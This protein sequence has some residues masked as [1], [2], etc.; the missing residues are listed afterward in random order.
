MKA[1]RT[2]KVASGGSH[3]RSRRRVSPKRSASGSALAASGIDILARNAD[4]VP[5]LEARRF[6]ASA[7]FGYD[8]GR[9]RSCGAAGILAQ[10]AAD[11]KP[12]RVCNPRPELNP[13]L[14]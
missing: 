2:R 13:K 1:E 10:V 14:S 6:S 3:Q 7:S 4:R 11:V 5:F 8:L 9:H 12:A